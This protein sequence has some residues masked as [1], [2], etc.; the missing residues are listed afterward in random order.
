MAVWTIKIT[1]SNDV[2]RKLSMLK[3]HLPSKIKNQGK[4]FMVVKKTGEKFFH[5]C[6]QDSISQPFFCDLHSK[7]F[8]HCQSRMIKVSLRET[9]YS[10]H[11]FPAL[12]GKVLWEAS[13]EGSIAKTEESSLRKCQL[14]EVISK[15][16]VVVI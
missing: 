8:R 15:E 6:L 9:F 14:I 2:R 10:N 3:I 7:V 4:I 11:D 5:S 13:F 16:S 12:A 1:D